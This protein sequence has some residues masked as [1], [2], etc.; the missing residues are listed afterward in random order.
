[1][2]RLLRKPYVELAA[3]QRKRLVVQLYRPPTHRFSYQKRAAIRFWCKL[4][5]RISVQFRSMRSGLGAPVPRSRIGARRE[6]D[7]RPTCADDT[8]APSERG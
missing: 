7:R 5:C 6:P 8:A 1:L 3:R 4:S 2:A